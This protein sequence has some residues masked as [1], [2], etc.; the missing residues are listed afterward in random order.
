MKP[1]DD[2]PDERASD[3]HARRPPRLAGEIFGEH[4]PQAIRYADLLVTTGIDHGLLGPREAPKVWDRHIINCAMVESLLPHRTRVIDIGSGAGLPGL[5]LAIARPDLRVALIE[6]LA[7]RTEWL[8]AAVDEL[9]LTQVT[10]HRARAE[11]MSGRI[12]ASVVTARAVAKLDQLVTWAWPLLPIGGRLLALKGQS[13][14]DELETAQPR[15]L[16]RGVAETKLHSLG[17]DILEQPVRVVE[18]VRAAV[19]STPGEL[20]RGRSTPRSRPR[21][22]GASAHE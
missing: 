2:G 13:A 5:A 3:A 10:V 21:S 4:L 18:V 14:A 22:T 16:A 6:P 17:E 7:R 1:H 8:Q 12:Q 15:L 19:D 20:R 9:G 11:E